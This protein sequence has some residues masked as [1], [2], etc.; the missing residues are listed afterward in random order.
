MKLNYVTISLASTLT[1]GLP[2]QSHGMPVNN[3]TNCA[4]SLN[5][6]AFRKQV[7]TGIP[8]LP[9]SITFIETKP[10]PQAEIPAKSPHYPLTVVGMITAQYDKNIDQGMRNPFI[11]KITATTVNC[12]PKKTVTVTFPDSDPMG[13][14]Y[15]S[16]IDNITIFEQQGKLMLK[17]SYQGKDVASK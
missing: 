15:G 2:T 9:P 4:V 16:N 10:S 14:G 1:L 13:T 5:V 8:G 7:K 12:D 17:A 11:K 3:Q 6:K